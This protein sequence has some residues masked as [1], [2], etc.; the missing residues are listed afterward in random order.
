MADKLLTA[1]E[2]ADLL[3]VP[4][5]TLYQWRV[6]RV[7]PPAARVGKFIRYRPADVERWVESRL[8]APSPAA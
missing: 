3:G 1:P 2:L 5:G 8:D 7:G 4:V 6:K